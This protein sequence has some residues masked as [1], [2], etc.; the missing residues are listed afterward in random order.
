M[1]TPLES[2]FANSEKL[3]SL[4]A[5]LLVATPAAWPPVPTVE[6]P[7]EAWVQ[8]YNDLDRGGADDRAVKA[9]RDAAGDIIVTGIS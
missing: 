1:K 3:L 7:V 2:S 4:L 6:V 9:V 8:R 5:T